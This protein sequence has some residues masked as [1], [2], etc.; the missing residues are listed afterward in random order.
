MGEGKQVSKAPQRAAE[1]SENDRASRCGRPRVPRMPS[2]TSR[3]RANSQATRGHGRVRD[4][5]CSGARGPY[6]GHARLDDAQRLRGRARADREGKPNR[7]AH[8]SQFRFF[9]FYFF[10]FFKFI[11]FLNLFF[12]KFFVFGPKTK[13]GFPFFGVCIK[14]RQSPKTSIF[15]FFLDKSTN[16]SPLASCASRHDR[17]SVRQWHGL[18]PTLLRRAG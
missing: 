2:L 9:K 3:R 6:H 10:F 11:S 13:I 16:G 4:E 12:F 18:S 1:S 17:G 14:A 15:L 7:R 5:P 8:A